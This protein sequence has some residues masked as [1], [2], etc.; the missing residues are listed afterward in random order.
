[1]IKLFFGGVLLGF[2]IAFSLGPAFFSVIQTSIDRGMRYAVFVSLGVITSDLFLIAV[3]FYGL[4][5]LFQILNIQIIM[6]FVGGI[7]LCMFGIYTFRKKPEILLRR[8]SNYKTP[9]LT[10]NPLIYFSKGFVMNVFNPFVWIFW[11]SAVSSIIHNVDADIAFRNVTIFFAGTLLTIFLLDV[12]KILLASML[13]RYLRLRIQ[14]YIN[15][16]IGLVLIALGVIVLVR[17][18]FLLLA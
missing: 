18:S 16:A 2:V 12:A 1:M 5:H 3:V 6:G 8:S 10:K 14:L 11:I 9:V 17:V 13:K 4:V 7:I 15:R